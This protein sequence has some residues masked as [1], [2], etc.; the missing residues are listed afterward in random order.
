MKEYLRKT[1]IVGTIGPASEKRLEEL[2]DAGLNVCRINYSHGSYEEQK[3][4]TEEIIR[5]RNEK[6]LPIPMI[7]D[8][9]G[10]E[11][12]TGMLY[13][14]IKEKIKLVDGQQFTLVAEEIVGNEKQVSISY[15]ELYKDVKEGTKILID[16]GAIEL[17]VDKIVGTDIV[18][19][20]VHGNELGSR[21]TCNLPGTKVN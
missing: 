2:F 20:V 6:E 21:K 12:R 10:P 11:I 19:T 8:M 18:T 5:I 16:D 13:T 7:L 3:W 4:K 15:S 9:K 1:K 14:G 17:R